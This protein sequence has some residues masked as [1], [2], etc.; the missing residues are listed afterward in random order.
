MFSTN[1]SVSGYFPRQQVVPSVAPDDFD[2]VPAG[3]AE[4]CFQFVDDLAI[5]AH[6]TVQPLQIAI[7]YEDQVVEL[8]AR[9]QRDGA[10]GFRLVRFSVAD[11]RPDFALG[12]LYKAPVFQVLHEACLI[13]GIQR[14]EPH[15]NTRELPKGTHQT[16]M[17][18]ARQHLRAPHL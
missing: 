9:S 1:A 17:R 11:K 7:D 13:D 16:G 2:H 3:A 8:L 6:W 15:A 5:A 12:L 18:I 10:H 14:S 4:R